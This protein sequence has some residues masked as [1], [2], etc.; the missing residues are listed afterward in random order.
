MLPRFLNFCINP[1]LLKIVLIGLGSIGHRHL[2]NLLHLG[3]NDVSVV[4]RSGVLPG[5]YSYL[6][7]YTSLNEALAANK[8]DAGI[9][10]TPTSFHTVSVKAL[11]QASVPNIY[12]EKPV[13]HNYDGL[14]EIVQLSKSY[15]NNIV[16]GYDLHFDPG[17]MK[18]KELLDTNII[19]KIVS[20]NAV[21]GQ[22]LPEWR[23]KKDY[24][25][26]ISAKKE[27][28]G[29]VM[30]D[31]IHE[32][33]YLHWLIGKAKTIAAQCSSTGALEIET[34]DVAEVLLR[35]SSGAIGTIHLDYLQQ[36]LVRNCLITGYNGSI[37]WNLAESKVSWIDNN[38]REEQF[39]YTGFE[40][41]D[42]FMSIMK[43]FLTNPSDSRLTNLNDGLE[44]LRWVLAAKQSA[45]LNEFVDMGTFNPSKN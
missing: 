31:L 32:F 43:S 10:C 9:V 19:G 23:P 17:M 28:G 33:D 1:T 39:D 30:L 13:S 44:S 35:F 14:Q 3:Y 26:G 45:D 5:E 20:V 11:L 24:R 34:E 40:R 7:V 18:V 36:K 16:V 41:N 37:K 21:V 12:I 38:K 2:C 25:K 29:G 15:A 6:P 4:R 42:R 27:T 22:Y 8:F